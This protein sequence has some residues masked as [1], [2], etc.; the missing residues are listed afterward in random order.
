[1]VGSPDAGKIAILPSPGRARIYV[2]ASRAPKLTALSFAPRGVRRIHGLHLAVVDEDPR[3]R[4]QEHEGDEVPAHG[5]A[6]HDQ[7][8]GR[9]AGAFRRLRGTEPTAAP[10]L[11]GS[12]TVRF[13]DAGRN[14]ADPRSRLV[15]EDLM[16]L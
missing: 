7:D 12:S 5:Q 16:S 11:R 8:D 3:L 9:Q 14:A 2:Y 15:V 4:H 1:M 13:R 10:G 6:L